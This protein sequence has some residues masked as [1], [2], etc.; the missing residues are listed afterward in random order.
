MGK[1]KIKGYFQK[2]INN[3]H[4]L[5]VPFITAGDGKKGLDNL[6]ERIEFLESCGVA[7]IELGVPF[8]DPVADG[9]M[10]QAASQRALQN[11]TT[12]EKILQVLAKTKQQRRVPIIL[13]SYIS[14]IFNYGIVKFAIACKEAGVSGVIIPD[15]PLEEEELVSDSLA[16]YDIAFI[17]LVALTS[18]RQRMKEIAK[19]SEGFVYVVSVTGT[20]GTRDHLHENIYQ[21]LATLK[22]YTKVPVLAGF[23]ISNTEQAKAL[24]EH[25]DGIIVGSKIV[26]LFHQEDYEAIRQFIKD[27]I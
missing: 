7:A 6:P 8:S 5:F 3:G 9:P 14:P 24:S 17:R 26:D 4:N 10:I 22:T 12:L 15:V 16:M 23:G 11:G 1:A 27:S 2:I 13:M 25:C 19:R 18:H 20:T 21:L